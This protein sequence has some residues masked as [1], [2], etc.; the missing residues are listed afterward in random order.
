MCTRVEACVHKNEDV[1]ARERRL[2][3]TRMKMFVHRSGGVCVHRSED[4]C[5]REWRCVY[6]RMR[7]YVPASGGVLTRE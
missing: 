1:C 3:Y 2:V 6:T 5:V 4:A 7:M